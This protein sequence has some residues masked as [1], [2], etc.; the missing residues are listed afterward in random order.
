MESIPEHLLLIPTIFEQHR[1]IRG[2]TKLI[3]IRARMGGH[4]SNR[5]TKFLRHTVIV[6]CGTSVA[7]ALKFFNRLKG[8]PEAELSVTLE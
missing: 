6:V 1:A 3:S 7:Q 4:R 2:D 5:K 8:E